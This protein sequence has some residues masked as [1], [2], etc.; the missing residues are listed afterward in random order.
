MPIPDFQ[1]IMSPLLAYTSDNNEYSLRDTADNLAVYFK[2]TPE[3]R[4]ELLPSGHTAVFDN[5]V[6]W[7]KMHLLVT[8]TLE[9]KKQVRKCK[10]MMY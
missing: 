3:E 1:T 4:Q 8:R 5:R 10:H 6:G 2:L 7:A 9:S